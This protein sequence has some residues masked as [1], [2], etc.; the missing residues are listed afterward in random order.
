M[1]DTSTTRLSLTKPEVGA[2]DD[3]WGDKLNANL[4]TLD[5]AYTLGTIL[6]TVSQT[7]GVPTGALIQK[8]SNANGRYRREADGE[9]IC[10]QILTLSYSSTSLLSAVWTFPA[11][12]Q[13][14]PD[15][16][17]VT[18]GTIAM[19]P[20]QNELSPPR[21]VSVGTSSL[22]VLLPRDTGQTDFG[23]SD[24]VTVS[25]EASGSWF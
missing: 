17:K 9:Q 8:G 15:G 3:T 6:G 16:Y 18:I 7:A 10:R 24:T 4:D 12:F 14:P 21:V 19:T 5:D 11:V 2:S 25:V 22:T 20:L 13:S 23:A 1:P